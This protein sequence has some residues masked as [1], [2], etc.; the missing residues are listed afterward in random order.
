MAT[1]ARL[2]GPG[3]GSSAVVEVV[4][5]AVVVVVVALPVADEHA[6]TTTAPS[7]R[8]AN[9]APIDSRWD[10]RRC[11]EEGLAMV[12]RGY[13]PSGQR[14]GR[15]SPSWTTVTASLPSPVKTDPRAKPRPPEADGV[16]WA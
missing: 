2:V 7:A 9:A 8:D 5:G 4:V 13:R 12:D 10:G 3:P 11:R 6:A 1:P 15:M 16:S 14:G